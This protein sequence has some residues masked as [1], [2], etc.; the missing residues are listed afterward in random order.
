MLTASRVK[1]VHRRT[2]NFNPITKLQDRHAIKAT[3]NDIRH[4]DSLVLIRIWPR[5]RDMAIAPRCTI[6]QE[7]IAF[8]SGWICLRV[9][10]AGQS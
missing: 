9:V 2:S 7:I 10:V 1:Q 6:Q 8:S 3:F 4:N 5:S